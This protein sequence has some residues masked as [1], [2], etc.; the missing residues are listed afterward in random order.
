MDID[1]NSSTEENK[2]LLSEEICPVHDIPLEKGFC[3]ICSI[4]YS[5]EGHN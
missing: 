4:C 2:E 1:T 5:C 3:E